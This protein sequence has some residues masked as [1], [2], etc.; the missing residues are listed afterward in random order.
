M[1]ENLRRGLTE[2]RDILGP[3]VPVTDQEIEDSL[4]YYYYDVSKTVDYIL[5]EHLLYFGAQAPCSMSALG[6]KTKSQRGKQNKTGPH[7]GQDSTGRQIL[8][9]NIL[10]LL[11]STFT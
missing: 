11:P 8:F 3:E 7:T 10:C 4:Y 5:G 1:A 9:P 2:V 6:Q